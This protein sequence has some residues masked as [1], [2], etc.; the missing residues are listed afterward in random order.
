MPSSCYHSVR[1]TALQ[2]VFSTS[3]RLI[4]TMRLSEKYTVDNLNERGAQS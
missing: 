2:S 4:R 1:F 3:S